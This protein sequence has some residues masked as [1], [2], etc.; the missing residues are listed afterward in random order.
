MY[1]I[2]YIITNI[3]LGV[4][5][6]KTLLKLLTIV[7][8]L[9]FAIACSTISDDT[10][11]STSDIEGNTTPTEQIDDDGMKDDDDFV[12][13]DDDLNVTSTDDQAYM[14]EKL[15]SSFFKEI[16]VDIKFPN[17]IDYEFDITRDDGI[18]EAKVEDDISNR[19]IYGREAFDF[20]FERLK[21]VSIDKESSFDSIKEQLISAFDLSNDYSEFEVDITFQD[22]TKIEYE[23]N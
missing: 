10:N 4:I 9:T 19:K 12:N 23:N 22:G 2:G 21:D 1:C 3:N 17:D 8:T 20:I 18:I 14:E 6:I 7:F 16:E 13:D 15:G 11:D 5:A